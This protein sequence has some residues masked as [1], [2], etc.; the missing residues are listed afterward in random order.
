MAITS[1]AYDETFVINNKLIELAA[2]NQKVIANNIANAETPGY[3]RMKLDFQKRLREAVNSGDATQ[4]SNLR[5][6]IEE[7]QTNPAGSDGNNIVLPIE[8]NDMMQ[9]SVFNNLL[10]SAFRT[11]LSILKNA[12]K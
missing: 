7:D 1:I 4:I 3:T 10:T 12:I 6:A 8:L 11:R 2:E 5:A 9:N